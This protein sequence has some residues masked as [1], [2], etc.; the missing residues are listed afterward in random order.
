MM[1]VTAAEDRVFF[2]LEDPRRARSIAAPG[3]IQIGKTVYFVSESIANYPASSTVVLEGIR[4]NMSAADINTHL[5]I[6]S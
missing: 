2:A 1:N 4:R 5:S 3:A 6:G